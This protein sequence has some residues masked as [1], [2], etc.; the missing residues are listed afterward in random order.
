MWE[1][2]AATETLVHTAAPGRENFA[3][4]L[5]EGQ[6]GSRLDIA[7]IG[8]SRACVIFILRQDEFEM[9]A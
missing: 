3:G 7:V 6:C 9:S 8:V 1:A 4:T 5:A 2:S